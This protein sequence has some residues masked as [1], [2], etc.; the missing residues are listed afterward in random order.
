MRQTLNLLTSALL[1]AGLVTGCAGGAAAPLPAQS[2]GQS[3]AQ[4]SPREP[5]QPAAQPSACVAR[6]LSVAEGVVGLR[7]VGEGE[8]LPEAVCAWIAAVEEG[9]G[10]VTLREGGTTYLIAAPGPA[11]AVTVTSP[12]PQLYPPCTTRSARAGWSSAGS[13]W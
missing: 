1:L 10:M 8:R 3:P 12:A 13:P 6:P 5:T 2:P 9:G 4:S 11:G 7:P